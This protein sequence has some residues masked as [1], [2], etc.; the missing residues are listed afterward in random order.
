VRPR[1]FVVCMN[2]HSACTSC[3]ADLTS[4]RSACPSLGCRIPC[5]H[6]YVPNEG[7]NSLVGI[8]EEQ[9]R[10]REREETL[11]LQARAAARARRVRRSPARR[12][13]DQLRAASAELA[14]STVLD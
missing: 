3:A 12:E 6:F 9:Q 14:G 4:A 7:L 11:A 13:I 2:G 5:S 1:F 8:L 10:A